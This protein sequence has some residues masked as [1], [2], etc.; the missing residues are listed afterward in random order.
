MATKPRAGGGEL[1]YVD[2]QGNKQDAALHAE[3][4]GEK[5]DPLARAR[6]YLPEKPVNSPT[7]P[8]QADK[9]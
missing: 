8:A 4:L 3:I 2:E 5:M 6:R 1:F 9:T 7:P